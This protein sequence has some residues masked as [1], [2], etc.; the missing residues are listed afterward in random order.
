MTVRAP[1]SEFW[2]NANIQSITLLTITIVRN[3]LIDRSENT[4]VRN[5]LIDRS[6]KYREFRKLFVGWRDHFEWMRGPWKLWD[7]SCALK[8]ELT[9][10]LGKEAQKHRKARNGHLQ[11]SPNHSGQKGGSGTGKKFPVEQKWDLKERHADRA[12]G[13]RLWG[14]GFVS[15][16]V[17]KEAQWKWWSKMILAGL[18]RVD[19][20]D[21]QTGQEA[22]WMSQ[23]WKNQN[24]NQGLRSCSTVAVLSLQLLALFALS[25]L[26]TWHNLG[27]V[28]RSPRSSFNI[29][30]CLD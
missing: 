7:F 19:G 9:F 17:E 20:Q 22:A 12:S 11:Q 14:A 26:G 18:C 13:M 25:K 1:T 2:R 8:K 16:V 15:L 10:L 5:W 21:R 30:P 28:C 29:F 27:R 6:E 3:W 23:A 24:L 4:I